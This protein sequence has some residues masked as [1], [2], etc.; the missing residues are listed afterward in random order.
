MR[1]KLR[2]W[3]SVSLLTVVI[4]G[5]TFNSRWVL[6]IQFV[7]SDVAR[8]QIG[9][10]DDRLTAQ[11]ATPAYLSAGWHFLNVPD[12]RLGRWSYSGTKDGPRDNYPLFFSK[13]GFTLRKS[14]RS[15]GL[16]IPF[17]YLTALIGVATA[18]SV[19]RHIRR[20]REHAKRCSQGLC[21]KCGYDVRLNAGRCPE[22]GEPLSPGVASPQAPADALNQAPSS[23]AT[24]A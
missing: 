4:I 10:V 20:V 24:R 6:A 23:S 5:W 2:H 16:F 1:L 18:W 9:A 7:Q 8:W 12:T 14:D 19:T 3:A 15:F 21:L 11:W 13:Y 22:C 17:S